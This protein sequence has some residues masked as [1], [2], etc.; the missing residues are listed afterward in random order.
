MNLSNHNNILII[1]AG[2]GYDV[3]CGLPLYL[4][5]KS[6][7]KN[8]HLANFTFT[9]TRRLK[10]FELLKNTQTC[11]KVLADDIKLYTVND[12]EIPPAWTGIDKQEYIDEHLRSLN[13]FPEGYLSK[14]LNEPVW[15]IADEGGM[16]NLQ[17]CLQSTRRTIKH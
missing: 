5:L 17:K 16:V 1:G 6:E 7:K 14:E 10:E 3:F 8:V 13:Y 12:I 9:D 2:G 4:K 11:Y 15:T